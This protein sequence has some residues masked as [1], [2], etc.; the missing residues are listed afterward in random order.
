MALKK[1]IAI[2]LALASL[3]PLSAFS[4]DKPIKVIVTFPPGGSSDAMVR[5]LTP[6][7]TEVLNAPV[8]VDNRP[9]A[10]GSIGMQALAKSPPDGTHFAV[11]AAGA[12]SANKSLYSKLPYDVDKDIEPIARMSE[13]PFV[14]VGKPDLPAKNLQELLTHIRQKPSD[15]SVGHGGNG[16]AMHLSAELLKQM[17]QTQLVQVPYRGTGPATMDVISGQIELAMTDLPAS[18]QQ[19][20]AGK[21]RAY[22]VTT[23]KRLDQLPDVPTMA[24]AGVPG[25]ESTGWFGLVAPKGISAAHIE[26]LSQALSSALNEPSIQESLRN[27]GLEP[28][29]MPPAAFK[30]YIQS[31]THKWHQVVTNANIKLD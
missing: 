11:G 2:G 1:L 10:G 13:I 25:Y 23:S 3:A 24:E 30:T 19:I 26:K 4:E 6:K 18:L 31:E 20:K 27:L 22:A 15:Y 12:L 14:L 8:I 21:L 16:T 28:A 29:Y 9:G 5:L 7:L 17:T